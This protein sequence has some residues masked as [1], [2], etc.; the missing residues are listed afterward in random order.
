M[1]LLILFVTLL[2]AGYATSSGGKWRWDMRH[3]G[4]GKDEYAALCRSGK[5]RGTMGLICLYCFWIVTPLYSEIYT[6]LNGNNGINSCTRLL[7]IDGSIGCTCKFSLSLSFAF[8]C[9]F[10]M[11]SY[12]VSNPHLV[13]LLWIHSLSLSVLHLAPLL[14]SSHYHQPQRLAGLTIAYARSSSQNQRLKVALLA[15]CSVLHHQRILMF[16]IKHLP[17]VMW[18]CCQCQCL[19]SK[20]V[21]ALYL[22]SAAPILIKPFYC[23][24][25]QAKHNHD[26]AELFQIR[27]GFSI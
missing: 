13:W 15:S 18:C 24:C 20:A 6:T 12:S 11:V 8:I 21:W 14:L 25:M 1:M 23:H 10:C 2:L 27:W 16:F 3:G 19:P 4:R 22:L 17:I 26:I 9:T 5:R 7:N